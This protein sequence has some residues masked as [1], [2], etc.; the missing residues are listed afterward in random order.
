VLNVKERGGRAGAQNGAPPPWNLPSAQAKAPN[1]PAR[2]QEV[3]GNALQR[4]FY[5]AGDRF[6]GGGGLP[7]PQDADAAL[8]EF[9]SLSSLKPKL[10][11]PRAGPP[12]PPKERQ[13]PMR[14]SGDLN[15]TPDRTPEPP[16]GWEQPWAATF[17]ALPP[18]QASPPQQGD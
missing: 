14:P 10:Q 7:P 3:S 2:P 6:R 16:A 4:P 12:Q 13:Q 17:P 9:A 15:P 1:P 11:P 5:P 8:W 18:P